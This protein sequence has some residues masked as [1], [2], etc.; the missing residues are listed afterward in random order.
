MLRHPD[1]TRDRIKQLVTRIEQLIYADRL[2]ITDLNVAGPVDRISYEAAQHLE[3]FQPAKP[4]DQYRPKWATFWFRV[5]ANV[6]KDWRG[7]RVDLLWDSQS[8]ATLWIDGKTMSRALNMTQGD[9]PDAILVGSAAG[10]E[11]IAFQVEMACNTKFGVSLPESGGSM[12][13]PAISPFH[14]R[15]CQLG[16]FD[17]QAW[18]LY[19]DAFVLAALE[20]AIAKDSSAGEKSWQ[21]LLLAELNRFV[22]TI[23]LDDR[24]T[25]SKAQAILTALYPQQKSRPHA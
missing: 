8:E 14:L 21:G 19:Y 1:Y 7:S 6:P 20:A 5:T 15:R 10:G 24:K 17:P 12:A 4:G 13:E 25:W 16:R 9:R 2:D 23:D 18:K 11:A 3:D 22:N